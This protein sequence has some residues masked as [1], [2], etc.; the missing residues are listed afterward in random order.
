MV[1]STKPTRQSGFTVVE[2]MIALAVFS[3][4]MMLTSMIIIGLSKQYQKAVYSTKLN[5]ASQTVHTLLSNSLSYSND[6]D[7]THINSAGATNH[8]YY[9]CADHNRYFWKKQSGTGAISGYIGL[10]KDSVAS[11]CGEPSDTN[12]DNAENLLPPRGFITKFTVEYDSTNKL[13]TISTTFNVGDISYFKLGKIGLNDDIASEDT[14]CL[15]ASSGGD[16]C[17]QNKYTSAV[18]N[19]VGSN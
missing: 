1:Y 15:S 2:M 17:A 14:V 9:F 16:F 7:D 6:I 10:Y 4:V 19:K 5:D 8:Y 11:G 3:A 12:A 18:V 13:Y